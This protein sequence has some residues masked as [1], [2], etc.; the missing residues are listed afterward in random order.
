MNFP[1]SISG[2]KARPNKV[3]RF[4][5]F[6]RHCKIVFWGEHFRNEKPAV[7]KWRLFF[8]IRHCKID[9]RRERF[10]KEVPAFF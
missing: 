6:I 4:L 3:A 1:A 7:T 9:F 10:W 8:P 2:R 5:F